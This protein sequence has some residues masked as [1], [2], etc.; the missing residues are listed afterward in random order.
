MTDTTLRIPRTVVGLFSTIVACFIASAVIA[1]ALVG[2]DSADF[3]IA[4]TVIEAGLIWVIMVA[5]YRRV[6]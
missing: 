4:V 5:C 1:L 3:G 2:W 6:L